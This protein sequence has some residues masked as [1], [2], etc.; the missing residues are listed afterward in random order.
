MALAELERA[1][2]LATEERLRFD[3]LVDLAQAALRADER[4]KARAYAEEQLAKARL[5]EFA[6]AAG[7][8]I[9][10]GNLVLGHLALASGDVE[11]AKGHLVGAGRTPGSAPLC[12]FGPSMVLAKELLDRGEREAVLH[13]LRLCSVFWQP[14]DQCL[15]QWI[16]TIEHGGVPDFGVR[17][18]L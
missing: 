12:S 11:G 18:F 14:D 9:H 8:A 2:E 4:E 16:W 10:Y 17:L 1:W 7:A 13:Y 6:D 5:P 15:D 3:L